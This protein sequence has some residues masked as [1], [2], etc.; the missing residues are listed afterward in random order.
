MADTGSICQR[1]VE[2]CF[3]RTVCKTGL[4]RYLLTVRRPQ[5]DISSLTL[6]S[7]TILSSHS[8]S[9]SPSPCN[10]SPKSRKNALQPQAKV[11]YDDTHM[12]DSMN[13]H[14]LYLLFLNLYKSSARSSCRLD[15]VYWFFQSRNINHIFFYQRG[16]R[17]ICA[18]FA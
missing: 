15:R 18:I 11:F 12:V 7:P 4:T 9:S 17:L 6:L 5:H 2:Q 16:Y 13:L 8:P 3:H 1:A 14:R 10:S